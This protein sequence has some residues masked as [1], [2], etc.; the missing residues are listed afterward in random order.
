MN[1][2]PSD[3]TGPP[4][5]SLGTYLPLEKTS[6]HPL[7]SPP[8]PAPPLSDSQL[9]AQPASSLRPLTPSKGSFRCLPPV[10]H[11]HLSP[12]LLRS[13]A[14]PT[15][16]Q[17]PA[18]PGSRP[19][20]PVLESLSCHHFSPQLWLHVAVPCCN[21]TPPTSCAHV[22][23]SFLLPHFLINGRSQASSTSLTKPSM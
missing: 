16:A 21:K 5:P 14:L 23:F 19:P 20:S 18:P 22:L 10:I 13:T 8:R 3:I 15:W 4:F 12:P 9:L 1:W 2:T 7:C 11:L 17:P 6:S